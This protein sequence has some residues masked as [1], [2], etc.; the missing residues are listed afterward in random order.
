MVGKS[1]S[2]GGSHTD[3]IKRERGGRSAEPAE[4]EYLT[5][6]EM[7]DTLRRETI[8]INRG[9]EMRTRELTVLVTDYARGR[10]TPEETQKRYFEHSK[11]WGDPTYGISSFEGRTD[12][13][14]L[15]EMDDVNRAL[16]RPNKL[17]GPPVSTTKGRSR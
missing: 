16:S 12:S 2:K 4:A 7:L 6:D 5:V 8:A 17:D 10:I 14:I 9:A 1:T 11:R 15:Q 3:R 13:Q